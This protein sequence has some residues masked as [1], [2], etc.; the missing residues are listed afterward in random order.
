MNQTSQERTGRQN[1]GS[2]LKR[3]PIGEHHSIDTRIFQDEVVNLALNNFEAVR[4][5]NR[6]LYGLTVKT[7]IRLCARSSY[8]RTFASVEQPELDSRSICGASHQTVQGVDFPDEMTL[9]QSTDGRIAGHDTNRI[10][11]VGYQRG[12]RTHPCG[13]G[14]GLASGMAPAD[15][16]HVKFVGA[17]G[18]H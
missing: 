11:P 2:A 8:R 13:C 9:T 3:F 12:S 7:A 4:F 18:D 6:S 5:A 10:A 16:N 14:S 15:H 17:G 1:D